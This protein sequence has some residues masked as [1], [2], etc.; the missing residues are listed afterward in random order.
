[1]RPR[2]RFRYW[3]DASNRGA[4]RRTPGNMNKL[5]SFALAAVVLS[6]VC[7]CDASMAFTTKFASDFVPAGRTVSVLG[8][9][10]DG[11]MSPGGWA[12]LGPHVQPALG[13]GACAIGYDVLA[14]ANSPLAE[15]IDEYTSAD[16]PSDALLAQ[17]APAARGDLILVLTYAGRLPQ[18]AAVNVTKDPAPNQGRGPQGGPPGAGGGRFSNVAPIGPEDPNAL[19]ISASV[20][21]IRDARSVALLALQYR[22]DSVDEAIAKFSAKLAE[23]FPRA[24]CADWNRDAKIDPDR[25]RHGAIE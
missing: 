18:H 5:Q 25:I 16:G 24:V 12:I 22:G 14:P 4:R 9:Y 15:A 21:S 7:A 13:G 1:M 11:R 19:D 6:A 2:H 17:L 3:L 20:Y 8:V 10:K 23:T